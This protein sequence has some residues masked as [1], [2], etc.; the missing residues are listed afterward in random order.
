MDIVL[1]DMAQLVLSR[2]RA[3]EVGTDVVC[4]DL[5]NVGTLIEVPV[6][7]DVSRREG[8]FVALDTALAGLELPAA[9]GNWCRVALYNPLTRQ[10]AVG[11]VPVTEVYTD[12]ADLD[13]PVY[14]LQAALADGSLVVESR[15]LGRLSASVRSTRS[16]LAAHA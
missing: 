7:S 16:A 5:P 8:V 11:P 1:F 14:G 4:V 10:V 6:P 12:G 2:R 13:V 15:R 3:P 9:G